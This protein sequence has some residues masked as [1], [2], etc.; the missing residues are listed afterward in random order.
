MKYNAAIY[1]VRYEYLIS[2][3]L[4]KDDF[5]VFYEMSELNSIDVDTELDLE[6]SDLLMQNRVKNN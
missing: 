6:I 1:I 5:Q 4:F 2:K 3:N